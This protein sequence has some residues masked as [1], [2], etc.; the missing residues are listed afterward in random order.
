VIAYEP[1]PGTHAHARGASPRPSL[2]TSLAIR[3]I[4]MTRYLVGG[5][6]F[7]LAVVEGVIEAVRR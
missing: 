1:I 3:A 4:R 5:V 6:A 2:A 7:G